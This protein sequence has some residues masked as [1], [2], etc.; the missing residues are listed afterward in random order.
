MKPLYLILSFPLLIAL[1]AAAQFEA[2]GTYSLSV[3]TGEMGRNINPL[4]SINGTALFPLPGK[5]DRISLGGE[6]GIGVYALMTM[7][8]NLRFSDGSGITANMTYSSNVVT[9]SFVTRAKAFREAKVNP[10]LNLKAGY[11]N[12]FSDVVVGEPEYGSSCRPVQRK[13]IIGD[14]ALFIAYGAGLQLDFSVLLKNVKPGKG[15]FEIIINRISGGSLDYI[16]TR[17]LKEPEE[18]H[19]PYPLLPPMPGKGIPLNMR[20]I[21][22]STQ[23]EHNHQVAEVYNSPLKMLDIRIGAMIRIEK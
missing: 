5:W 16:N 10:F 18:M 20:F 23:Q 7:Q 1:P 4:H 15:S 19:N 9:A 17:A 14:D 2:G 11:A 8:R 6:L 21:N 13:K 22:V 12:F 3:P